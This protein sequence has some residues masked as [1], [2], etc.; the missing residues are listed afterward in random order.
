MEKLPEAQGRSFWSGGCESGS[1]RM[2]LRVQG[3]GMIGADFD[4]Q[5]ALSPVTVDESRWNTIN[6]GLVMLSAG[7]QVLGI[8]VHDGCLRLNWI[9]FVKE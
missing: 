3:T 8:L 6:L 2:E 7:E 1:Y 9:E 5:T 4:M